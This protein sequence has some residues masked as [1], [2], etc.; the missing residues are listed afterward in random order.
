VLSG[1]APADA[2]RRDLGYSAIE[3]V[4]A[5]S[6]FSVLMSAF[7]SAVMLMTRTTTITGQVAQGAT[8]L[9]Q[10]LDGLGRAV[11]SASAVNTPSLVGHDLYIEFR[12][13]AVVSGS[14]AVCSQWRYRP[15]A[16]VI[17]ERTWSTLDAA[18]TGWHPLAADVVNDVLTQPPFTVQAADSVHTLPR[19]T[20][21]IRIHPTG[22]PVT[23]NSGI[24][25]A[26]NY[27]AG[28]PSPVCTEVGRS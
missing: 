26:R 20:F 10:V 27:V 4:I 3:L 2:R 5:M 7:M 22:S 15:S 18:P 19:V 13:D 23:S 6:V 14:A 24:Y 25:T 12:T 17:E 9:R 28:G 8:Q 16:Q 1:P 11:A 21:D